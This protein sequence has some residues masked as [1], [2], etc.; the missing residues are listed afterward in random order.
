MLQ[1]FSNFHFQIHNNLFHVSL[2]VVLPSISSTGFSPISHQVRS[3]I[4]AAQISTTSTKSGL[5]WRS[6]RTGKWTKKRLKM[7]QQHKNRIRSATWIKHLSKKSQPRIVD[8]SSTWSV[9]KKKIILYASLRPVLTVFFVSFWLKELQG[10][11]ATLPVFNCTLFDSWEIPESTLSS[12]ESD[13][14]LSTGDIQ[15]WHT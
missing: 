3:Q 1:K 12:I 8:S 11:L 7:Q 10:L 5:G 15:H 6:F 14:I 9:E 13:F 2:V 4:L